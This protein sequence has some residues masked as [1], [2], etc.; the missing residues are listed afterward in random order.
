MK[1]KFW[2]TRGA[3]PASFSAKMHRQK[4]FDAIQAA[5]GRELTT[6]AAI[7]DFIDNQLPFSVSYTYG[8]NTPCVEIENASDDAF[9][10]LDAGSG[11]RDFAINLVSIHPGP[12]EFHILLSHLHWDHIQGFPFFGPAYQS[13][14]T[15]IIH[16]YHKNVEKAFKTMMSD[17][18]FPVSWETLEA[19]IQFEVHDPAESFELLNYK[20]SALEQNHVGKSYAL[21]LEQGKQSLIYATDC[22]HTE[23]YKNKDYPFISFCKDADLLIFDSMAT[24]KEKAMR[25]W[26]H[27]NNKVGLE[28]ANRAQAKHLV[29]FHHDRETDDTSLDEQLTDSQNYKEELKAEHPSQITVAY[30]GLELSA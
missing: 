18:F 25:G 15:V 27:S 3:L 19:N 9:V 11:I 26:G 12:K 10:L 22:E 5:Q 16:S 21:K 8:T 6:P 14:N 20:I 1:V 29:L 13:S 30:D 2:G 28:L 24:F 4:V 17:P 23:A 7:N